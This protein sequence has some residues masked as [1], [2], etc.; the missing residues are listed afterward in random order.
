MQLGGRE[1]FSEFGEMSIILPTQIP[2]PLK[3]LSVK[4]KVHQC[5]PRQ[6]SEMTNLPKFFLPKSCGIQ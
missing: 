3:E 1:N 2:D 4:V 5:F 6:N